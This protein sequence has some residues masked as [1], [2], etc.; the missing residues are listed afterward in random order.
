MILILVL[1]ALFATS[2]LI[3]KILLNYYTTPIFLAGSRLFLAGIILIGYQYWY[4]RT[5]F[6][7][8][9]KHIWLY[10]QIVFFGM[11]INY[12]LRYSALTTLSASKTAFLF[13]LSPFLT[14]LYSYLVFKETLTKQQ[15]LG[16]TIGFLGLI[17]ILI[18]SS[19]LEQ[20]D[21]EFFFISMSEFAV[22]LSV[23]CH[24]YSWIIMRKLIRHKQYS[25]I[26]INGLTMFIG[27]ILSLLVSIPTEGIL[28]ITEIQPFLGWLMITIIVSN[29]ICHNL[30][31]YLLKKYSVTFLSFAG[32]LSPLFAALYGW[33]FL[34][35]SIS[36]HFYLSMLIVFFGLFIF[37]QDEF[38]KNIEAPSSVD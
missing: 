24:S 33:L 23:A 34:A 30:Y 13:N 11:F 12:I 8:K 5:Q 22:M 6:K 21:G 29:I 2:F 32:F 10:A 7:F 38:N 14:A 36:W 15:W 18:S 28:P 26:T 20:L 19:P 25:P 3:G 35:E 31:G 4:N 37:Y 1:Y 17:P 16:L 9:K 27:G